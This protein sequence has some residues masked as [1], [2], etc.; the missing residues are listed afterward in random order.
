MSVSC[1][2]V[3]HAISLDAMLSTPGQTQRYAPDFKCE[4]PNDTTSIVAEKTPSS[5]RLIVWEG[6]GAAV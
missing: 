2:F 5:V 6:N 4:F 1:L 3:P